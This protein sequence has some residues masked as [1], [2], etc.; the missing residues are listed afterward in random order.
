MSMAQ[1]LEALKGEIQLSEQELKDFV[2]QSAQQG[3]AIHEVEEGLW[4]RLLALGHRHLGAFLALHGDGDL[5]E[6]ITL[7]DGQPCQRLEEKH[8]RRYV[9]IFGAFHLERAVYGS[10]KGQKI[11]FV[12]LDNRLQLPARPFSYVLQDWDQSLCVEEAFKQA[13]GTVA[14]ILRLKQSVDSLERMNVQMAEHVTEFRENRPMPAAETEGELLV[15]SGDGKGVVLRRDEP[16]PAGHRSKGEKASQKRMAVV[17]TAYT[18]DRYWRTAEQVVAALFGELE[19]RPERPEPQNK[20]V[21]ASLGFEDDKGVLH[22]GSEAVY[23]WLLNEV[24]ER[25]RGFAKE[26]VVLHDGEETLWAARDRHLPHKNSTDILDFLHV[27][28][29]LWKAAHAF[30]PEG[31]DEAELLVRQLMLRIL[32]GG[33]AGV[34]RGLR[35]M[36]TKRG[37]PASKKKTI[38]QVCGYFKSNQERMRYHD[39]LAK[40]YPIATG[41]IEGAC[42][43]LVKDRMERAGMHWRLEGAQAML[44]MRSTYINGDWEAYN[45]F[46]I[47]KET[48]RLYPHRELV[49]GE[50][51]ALAV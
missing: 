42:R 31:S 12:P 1:E 38:T 26:M 45:A 5:G 21:W 30:H 22:H 16:A 20:H 49:E 27:T 9:S 50:H 36:A 41:V 23:P 51:Y 18:V 35:E 14:R 32:H 4:D 46:R 15:L 19:K 3:K 11:E 10:R 2:F 28:P 6:T 48:A 8:E 39:Y 37:L 40:G 13:S 25:N 47:D 17:G 34:I 43:H 33:V 29:R 24:A 44:D 7:P